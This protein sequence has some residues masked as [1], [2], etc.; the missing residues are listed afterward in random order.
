MGKKVYL[1]SADC[2]DQF[3]Y[4]YDKDCNVICAPSGGFT[5]RGDGACA[6]FKEMA[7]DETLVWQDK[8]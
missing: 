4:L 6:N 1:F 5:G 7:T 3:N 8:R 2:C